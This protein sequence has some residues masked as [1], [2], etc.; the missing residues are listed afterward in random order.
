MKHNGISSI[1]SVQAQFWFWGLKEDFQCEQLC[2]KLH[3][4]G[5]RRVGLC[6]KT[7]SVYRVV[8]NRFVTLAL[9]FVYLAIQMTALELAVRV[10]HFFPAF[11]VINLFLLY[12]FLFLLLVSCVRLAAL[13][14]LFPGG[15]PAAL[16]AHDA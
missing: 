16:N 8:L 15:D 9:R 13:Q 11:F 14:S 4:E 3:A 12:F 6:G 7:C 1:K 5:S 10:S 2:Q